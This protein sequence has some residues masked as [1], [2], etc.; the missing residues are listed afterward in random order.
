MSVRRTT[1]RMGV[2]KNWYNDEENHWIVKWQ[3]R[4]TRKMKQKWWMT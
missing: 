2:E 1:K 4:L 3:K